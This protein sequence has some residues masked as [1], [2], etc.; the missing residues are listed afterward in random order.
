MERARRQN[1]RLTNGYTPCR[2]AGV[3]PHKSVPGH[4]IAMP[5]EMPT[6]ALPFSQ[7]GYKTAWLGKWCLAAPRRVCSSRRHV[8]WPQTRAAVCR[9]ACSGARY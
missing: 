6:V 1:D 7:A 9:G 5:P 2:P 8:G 4:E 3:Y